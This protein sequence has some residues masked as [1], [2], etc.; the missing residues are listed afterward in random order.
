MPNIDK[1]KAEKVQKPF[2]KKD[3]SWLSNAWEGVKDF[4]TPSEGPS[5]SGQISKGLQD[6]KKIKTGGIPPEPSPTPTA[7][8][9]QGSLSQEEMQALQAKQFFLAGLGVNWQPDEEDLQVFRNRK[10]SKP[11]EE[12]QPAL[13]AWDQGFKNEEDDFIDLEEVEA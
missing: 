12:E 4:F 6:S 7:Q 9:A 1:E 13:I 8:P 10:E 3:E 2:E 11:I 5:Y